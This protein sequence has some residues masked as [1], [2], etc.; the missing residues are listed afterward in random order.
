MGELD[1]SVGELGW[2]ASF[3]P[4]SPSVASGKGSQKDL[5]LMH[6][7]VVLGDP[8]DVFQ[9][10]GVIREAGYSNLHFV[11]Y[12]AARGRVARPSSYFSFP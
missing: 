1:W 12:I 10:P 11:G 2:S 3:A 9:Y 7:G 6:V 8:L 4:G 5:G